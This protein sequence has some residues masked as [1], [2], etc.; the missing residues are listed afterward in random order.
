MVNCNP[1]T[2]STDYDTSDRLYF[3]PLTR[4][5]VLEIVEAEKPEGVIVQFGGQTPLRLAVPLQKAGVKL[6]GTSADA[7]DRAEDR[8]RFGELVRKLDLRAPVWGTAHG[9]AEA[10]QIAADIGYPVMVR[11]SYVL[12]GRA[13]EIVYDAAS[14][15]HFVGQALE[16]SRREAL[17]SGG[18]S[19]SGDVGAPILI[20]QFLRD[21]IEV[22]VDVVA[23]GQQAIIGGV[24]EH[25]EEAGIH[26]GDSACSLPP[27]T[28]SAE[29]IEGIKTQ[30]RALARELDV[31]GLMNVQFAVPRDGRGIFVLEV[32]PRASRTVPFVSKVT[33]VP[34]AKIAARIAVGRTL[35]EL[36][37]REVVPSHIAVKEAVFPF[38]KFPGV[39][40]LLGPEMRSTGEV[41][42]ID[43]TFEAAF[44]KSQIGAG[45]RLPIPE[46]DGKTLGVFLSVQDADKPLAVP[47]ARRL[48]ELGFRV[49]ASTGT[50]RYLQAAGVTVEHCNKVREGRP[51]C[52][53]K[54]IDGEIQ[55][56]INTTQGAEAIK[57]SFSLRRTA[58]MR[59]LPYYTTMSG[60]R[61]AVGAIAK[62]QAGSMTVCSLQEFQHG[63]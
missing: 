32:N 33:G 28:L 6:L 37:V 19:G 46:P 4:E 54:I 17:A 39:D 20:D 52:V 11:P 36:G 18:G 47:V 40:T 25:I 7:I 10:R 51:H 53:D 49:M 55:V 35:A 30:A 45:T 59:G 8:K 50:H 38:V 58:L 34:L 12:G 56:V 1:E 60:A 2:V 42:G 43:R 44:A 24:M 27:F 13:M 14:L 57:D 5:D 23:D 31:R 63:R 26:S 22:D 62:L 9:L 41:M 61:A 29:I 16:A 15:E 48:R 3:E 21:A